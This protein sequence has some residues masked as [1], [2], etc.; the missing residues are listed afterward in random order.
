MHNDQ[1]QT[2]LTMGNAKQKRFSAQGGLF[3]FLLVLLLAACGNEKPV[4]HFQLT[5]NTGN[6]TDSLQYQLSDTALTVLKLPRRSEN[7]MA[8]VV[9]T[10]AVAGNDTLALIA[11]L[12]VKSHDCKEQHALAAIVV[13]FRNDS[14]LMNVDPNVNHP[15]ELDYAVRLINSLVPAAYR[16]E[17]IDM[18]QAIE[19]DGKLRI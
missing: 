15:K 7:K 14:A 1:L 13:S 4:P 18:Q 6:G 2:Q 16:L 8:E 9:F 5:I 3:C 19:L 17:F 10:G 11:K 12:D